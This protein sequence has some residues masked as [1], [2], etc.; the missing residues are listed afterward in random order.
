MDRAKEKGQI[1][2][3]KVHIFLFKSSWVVLKFV[4]WKNEHRVCVF[5]NQENFQLSICYISLSIEE[6][7]NNWGQTVSEQ[8]EKKK[9]PNHLIMHSWNVVTTAH[10]AEWPFRSFASSL[11]FNSSRF[12]PPRRQF[13]P[14]ALKEPKNLFMSYETIWT[15]DILYEFR[16]IWNVVENERWYK[17]NVCLWIQWKLNPES[18][19][20]IL[21]FV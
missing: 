20:Q 17:E 13:F 4:N 8:P 18:I 15:V 5:C 14:L 6:S 16:K 12:F 10:E 1:K 3:H 11:L 7:G 19:L 21:L 9:K 2:K